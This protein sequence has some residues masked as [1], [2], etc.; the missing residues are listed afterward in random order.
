MRDREIRQNNGSFV[1]MLNI[2]E[3]TKY[4]NEQMIGRG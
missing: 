4:I 3:T 2:Q 1:K